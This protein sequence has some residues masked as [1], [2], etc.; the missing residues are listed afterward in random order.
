MTNLNWLLSKVRCKTGLHPWG[1]FIDGSVG[2]ACTRPAC[3]AV[4]YDLPSAS[5]RPAPSNRK[6]SWL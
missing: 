1:Y 4:Q 5:G 3:P 6:K 2:R